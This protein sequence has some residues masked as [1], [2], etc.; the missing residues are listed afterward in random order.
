MTYQTVLE[1]LFE[2][3]IFSPRL[4]FF[5]LIEVNPIQKFVF[6]FMTNNE[7]TSVTEVF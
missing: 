2:K 3:T 1:I 4:P 7:V 5:V 6:H